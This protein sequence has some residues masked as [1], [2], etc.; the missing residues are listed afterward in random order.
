MSPDP[1]WP[2]SAFKFVWDQTSLIPMSLRTNEL[3]LRDILGYENKPQC[4]DI[5]FPDPLQAEKISR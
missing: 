4:S 1:T 5:L 3:L 2:V